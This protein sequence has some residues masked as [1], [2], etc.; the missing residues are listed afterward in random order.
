MLI[1]ENNATPYEDGRWYFRMLALGEQPPQPVQLPWAGGCCGGG[2][3]GGAT[4][5]GMPTATPGGRMEPSMLT[6]RAGGAGY[7]PISSPCG[8]ARRPNP[9][10][11]PTDNSHSTNTPAPMKTKTSVRA[12]L[13]V[14]KI[15]ILHNFC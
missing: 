4:P 8:T 13:G 7:S 5:Q 14:K 2:G 9:I 10:T 3:G 11:P 12:K 15:P 1:P 6:L